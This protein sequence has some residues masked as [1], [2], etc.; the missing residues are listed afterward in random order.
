MVSSFINCWFP[1]TSN[2]RASTLCDD[3][4]PNFAL[5]NFALLS[6]ADGLE[7]ALIVLLL[8]F[9]PVLMDTAAVSKS[10]PG[11]DVLVCSA[12]MC[13][14]VLLCS[15]ITSD[16]HDRTSASLCA[17]VT[18]MFEPPGYEDNM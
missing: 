11:S 2:P 9:K 7:G 15:S 16:N 13:T 12:S 6:F 17:N 3:I 8:I 14:S 1:L 10:V 5:L 18:L 4:L